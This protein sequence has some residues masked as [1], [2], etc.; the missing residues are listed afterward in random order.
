[1][2]TATSNSKPAWMAK[3]TERK[4][5]IIEEFVDV[6]HPGGGWVRFR[7]NRCKARP[8][9]FSDYRE[10]GTGTAGTAGIWGT[11]PPQRAARRRTLTRTAFRSELATLVG[12][13]RADEIIESLEE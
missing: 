10:Q 11:L 9:T 5:T 6:S 3:V 7:V 8:L 12:A 1:M 13:E 4:R 2:T